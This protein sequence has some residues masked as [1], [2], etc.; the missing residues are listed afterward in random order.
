MRSDVL[1]QYGEVLL[2]L[3]GQLLQHLHHQAGDRAHPGDDCKV[4]I[5]PT[6]LYI[7]IDMIIMEVMGPLLER[8]NYKKSLSL[9][10]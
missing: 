4:G 10:F 1:L 2:D 9:R 3:E 5:R 7:H 6:P 8:N